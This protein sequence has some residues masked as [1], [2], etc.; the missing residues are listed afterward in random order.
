MKRL[1]KMSLYSAVAVASLVLSGCPGGDPVC[2]LSQLEDCDK[3]VV[4]VSAERTSLRVNESTQLSARGETSNGGSVELGTVTFS[5]SNPAIAEVDPNTGV[6]TARGTGTATLTATSSQGQGTLSLKVE[7]G[8]VHRGTIAQ[9]ETWRAKDNPHVVLDDVYVQGSS[10]PVL[11]IEPGVVVRVA[12]GSGLSIGEDEPGTLK[13]EGTAQQPIRFE[14]D[15]QTP[16]RGFWRSVDFK[17]QSGTGSKLTHA[18]LSHCGSFHPT[19]QRRPCI[20]IQGNFTGGGARPVLADVSIK[21]GAGSGVVAE[22]DGAFA[23]GSARVSVT[24]SGDYPFRIQ[25]NYASTLPQGGTL[26]ANTPNAV[27]LSGGTVTETQTWPDLGVPYVVADRV[28]VEGSRSPV[29]TLPAGLVLRMTAGSSFRVGEEN[30]GGLQAVGTA[31][32]PIVFTAHSDGPDH[33][34]WDGL[35][36]YSQTLPA[37]R[38]TYARVEYAGRYSDTGERGNIVIVKDKGELVTH[39]HLSHS[40]LCGIVRVRT[41]NL[42]TFATDF[43]AAG[44]GNTFEDN[45]GDNQCGP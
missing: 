24:S 1:K 5:S 15:T 38:L 21:D 11:T 35:F 43:T 26:E 6:V 12:N 44:L 33:G 28:N 37:S 22:A 13:A 4:K 14:A 17:S 39:T 27:E 32:K 8:S 30:P 40:G 18:T 16:T 41:S 2:E 23:P 10:H 9:S 34:F 29:L 45:L 7:G 19:A 42:E 36:F 20:Y 3:P 31:Q 25:P